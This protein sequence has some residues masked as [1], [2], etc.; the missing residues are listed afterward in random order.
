MTTHPA[1]T[2]I[3]RIDQGRVNERILSREVKTDFRRVEGASIKMTARFTSAEGKRLFVRFFNTLQLN[4]HFI[5]V[6]ARTRLDTDAVAKVEHVL[7]EMVDASA[8]ALNQAID[9]AEA[10]F[11]TNGIGSIAT[12]DT[13]ALEI[14]VSILSSLGRRYL[15]VLAKLD[16]LMPMLQ[17]LEIHDVITSQAV[18]K[19]RAGHKRQ[20]R[21]VANAA[22]RLATGLRKEMDA[23]AAAEAEARAGGPD[24]RGRRLAGAAADDE[25]DADEAGDPPSSAER[26]AA[27][28]IAAMAADP[29]PADETDPPLGADHAADAP[30]S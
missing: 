15:E 3:V 22:R 12:Y 9:G 21:D 20:V 2:A 5:S 19:E 1:A 29:M 17:T 26:E 28:S 4:A 30:V 27:N 7:R 8:E 24:R 6:I 23:A 13:Q 18:D 10:L 11:K 25:S 14:E 16:Q